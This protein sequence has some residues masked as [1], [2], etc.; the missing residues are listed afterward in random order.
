MPSKYASTALGLT[1]SDPALNFGPLELPFV[2]TAEMLAAL[3]TV[4]FG[5]VDLLDFKTIPEHSVPLQRLQRGVAARGGKG[6]AERAPVRSLE[7][8]IDVVSNLASLFR[9]VYSPAVGAAFKDLLSE[10]LTTMRKAK[11]IL[12]ADAERIVY[13]ALDHVAVRASNSVTT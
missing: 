13:D 3:T 10:L 8:L 12:L 9:H 5:D 6:P 7:E 1:L 11:H 4:N 2:V